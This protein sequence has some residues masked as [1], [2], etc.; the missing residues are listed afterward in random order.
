MNCLEFWASCAHCA[1]FMI[2]YS[3]DGKNLPIFAL[4][5]EVKAPKPGNFTPALRAT[6]KHNNFD[7]LF[8]LNTG[9]DLPPAGFN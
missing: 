5:V 3:A 1:A 6:S 9:C 8:L 4:L 2:F 7:Y